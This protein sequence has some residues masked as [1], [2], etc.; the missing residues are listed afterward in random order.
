MWN[1][2]N[3]IF[4]HW[5]S[6]RWRLNYFSVLDSCRSTRD[7]FVKIEVSP[8]THLCVASSS[9][10]LQNPNAVWSLRCTTHYW[11]PSA[12]QILANYGDTERKSTFCLFSSHPSASAM[13]KNARSTAHKTC[14]EWASI[15]RSATTSGVS[16]WLAFRGDNERCNQLQAT[17]Y[18]HF[19]FCREPVVARIVG[20]QNYV[21]IDFQHYCEQCDKA[22]LMPGIYVCRPFVALPAR[23]G[24]ACRAQNIVGTPKNVCHCPW[25]LV[26]RQN[27]LCRIFLT[28]LSYRGQIQLVTTDALANGQKGFAKSRGALR[29]HGICPGRVKKVVKNTAPDVR[30][31]YSRN[32]TFFHSVGSV[33][34]R[35]S[36]TIW[37][38]QWTMSWEIWPKAR[39]MSVFLKTDKG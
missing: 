28:F 22:T 2:V 31:N 15:E 32:I 36:I 18:A 23:T 19:V 8:K 13:D 1:Q 10:F 33:L 14:C 25:W 20:L 11:K 38:R 26:R 39:N 27:L 6:R 4:L 7:I 12:S 29:F 34:I 21:P 9:H 35:S 16:A 30:N 37:S 24:C 17:P 3:H 5:T